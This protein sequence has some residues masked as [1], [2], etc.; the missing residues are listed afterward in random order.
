MLAISPLV[1][2]FYYPVSDTL[3]GLLLY[4]VF[5]PYYVIGYQIPTEIY[6]E[7]VLNTGVRIPVEII[8]YAIAAVISIVY[9]AVTGDLELRRPT[10]E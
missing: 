7:I 5:G 9:E 10:A 6:S 8:S 4:P 3:P 1:W 2:A